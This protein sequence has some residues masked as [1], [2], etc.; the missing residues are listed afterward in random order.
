MAE[1]VKLRPKRPC[2]ICKKKSVQK[3]HPF[4]SQHCAEIDLS[5]WLD[6]RY[7]IPAEETGA[8]QSQDPE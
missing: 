3:F 7:A 6:G 8:D 5:R 2:P 4:C 1:L